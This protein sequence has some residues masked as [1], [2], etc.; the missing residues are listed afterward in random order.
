MVGCEEIKWKISEKAEF[1]S[2]DKNILI[3]KI[4]RI[5]KLKVSKFEKLIAQ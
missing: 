5:Y 4:N 3:L 1:L 2:R